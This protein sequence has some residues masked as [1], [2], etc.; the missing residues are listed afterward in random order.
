MARADSKVL[1]IEDD[2]VT[3]RVIWR[4][5][6]ELGYQLFGATRALE[7]LDLARQHLPSIILTDLYLPD[8]SGL[9][10]AS[11]LRADARFARIPIVAIIGED[12]DN[13]RDLSVA[14]GI[15]GFLAKPINVQALAI[16]MEFFLSGGTDMIADEGRI[17]QARAKLLS[18]TV[19]RLEARIRELET[20]NAELQRL[21]EMK[22]SFIQLTAHELR[23][24]LTLVQGYGRLLE[25]H[26]PLR[27]MMEQDPEVTILIQGLSDSITRMQG[28]IEDILIVSRIMTNKIDLNL[29]PL[30]L[31]T[32]A[33]RA[34]NSFANA[35][36]ERRIRLVFDESQFPSSMRADADLLYMT[37][38]NLLS[39]AIKYTP[40][41]G[42]IILSAQYNNHLVRLSV[43]DSGIGIDPA[44]HEA[45]FERLKLPQS[46]ETHGTS[47]TAFGGGGLGLGLAICKGVV[48]AHGGRIWVESAGYDPER[49]PG[50][51]FIV[52]LPLSV[53]KGEVGEPSTA[54]TRNLGKIRPLNARQ[55]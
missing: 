18:E 28:I 38:V 29:T 50:S 25:D 15:N 10:L 55:R 43:K 2:S 52:V 4:R 34:V 33:R 9:E 35:L 24:P 21:D 30:N 27:R 8:M 44:H 3:M 46:I 12:D 19:A 47:K 13:A 6:Q 39:N 49:L 45:I 16:Q 11:S 20:K 22:D 32:L 36:M 5:L 42:Q 23:T 7:G 1:I 31:G 53:A 14:A 40:D 37:L 17:D 54:T 51:E 41:G 26:P 48:E